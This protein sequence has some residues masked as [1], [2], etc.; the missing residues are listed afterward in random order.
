[1]ISQ[2]TTA[3][4]STQ[5][6]ATLARLDEGSTGSAK[7]R[8]HST[9][10]APV[11]GDTP[12]ATVF[13]PRPC[14]SVSGTQLTLA[15]AEPALVMVAGIPRWAEL[16]AADDVV[17]HI[18]DVTDSVGSGFYKVTGAETP[19]GETSPYFAAGGLLSLGAVVY[20]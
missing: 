14:G 3:L 4:T 19:P 11:A 15:V 10:V 2:S 9:L 16:V 18:G 5:L 17:L 1:M 8:I 7:I 20:S 12:M 13:L 6:L